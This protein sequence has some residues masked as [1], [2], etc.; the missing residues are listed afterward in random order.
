M[1]EAKKEL[2]HLGLSD[3]EANVYLS[4]LELG[5]APVQDIAK[6]ARVN[7]ATTYVMI[8]SLSA[9]GLMSSFAKGKK[10]FFS[11]ETPERLLSILRLQRRELE[12]KEAELEEVLPSLMALHNIGGE[13]PQV[14]FL[15][16]REGLA[17]AQSSFEKKE[18]PL[19]NMVNAREALN[20]H[21]PGAMEPHRDEIFVKQKPETRTLM[22]G[23]KEDC[24]EL[25]GRH[26]EAMDSKFILPEKLKIHGEISVRGDG[27]FIFSFKTDIFGVVIESQMMADTLMGM[28]ELAWEGAKKF[29]IGD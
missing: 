18:G 20:F 9:R 29:E 10:K 19:V 26:A 1:D 4:S 14:R 17:T 22:V 15:E 27:I 11:A 3:K 23:T 25:L 21:E 8:E 5:P 2:I 28:F 13:K 12:E 24:Q 16:G 7:R 6:R